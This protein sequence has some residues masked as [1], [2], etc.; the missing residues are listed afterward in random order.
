MLLERFSS[1]LPVCL[2]RLRALFTD[3]RPGFRSQLPEDHVAHCGIYGRAP[4]AQ[5]WHCGV[6]VGWMLCLGSVGEWLETV[7]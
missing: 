5:L 6:L 2:E 1:F 4:N 7:T 3:R